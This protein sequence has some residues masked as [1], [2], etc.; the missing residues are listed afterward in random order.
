MNDS[1]HT[2]A[3]PRYDL[4]IFDFD[5]TLADSFDWF[6]TFLPTLTQRFRLTPLDWS[7]RDA[8]RH[9]SARALVARL[10]VRWWQGPG[11]ARY[12]RRCM[13]EQAGQIPLFEGVPDM[14]RHLRASGVT[15]AIVT[16]NSRTN[17][18]RILGPQ[19]AALVDHYGCGAPILGKKR[20][21]QRVMRQAGASPARTLCIG[22]E[23][24]DADVAR[25]VGADF[26]PVSWGYTLPEAFVVSGFGPAIPAL[27]AVAERVLGHAAAPG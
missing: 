18:A 17:V 27:P 14:L 22:D 4:V 3:L 10:G 25:V 6:W 7:T 5:G 2:R 12:A 19:L 8:Y 23:L 16:S 20:L 21:T 9:L 15:I 24:R 11:I 1:S 13:T 26:A